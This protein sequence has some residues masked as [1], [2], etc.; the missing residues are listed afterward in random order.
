[1]D[2]EIIAVD[3]DGTLCTNKWPDIGVPNLTLIEWLKQEA[4]HGTRLI[5]WTCRDGEMLEQAKA[6]CADHGLYF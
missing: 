4:L 5:L 2:F 3:F 6:W 1:M